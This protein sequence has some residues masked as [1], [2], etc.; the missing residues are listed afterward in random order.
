M[1]V[2]VTSFLDIS[3]FHIFIITAWPHIRYY[4]CWLFLIARSVLTI[5]Y[6]ENNPS[7]P[8]EVPFICCRKLTSRLAFN[9]SDCFP[10]ISYYYRNGL[11]VSS[12]CSQI[13]STHDRPRH[14]LPLPHH[15]HP[16]HHPH[17]PALSICLQPKTK[18]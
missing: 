16:M 15:P 13:D 5:L 7:V 17:P 10:S 11:P 2:E 8:R 12:R 6:F 9:S 4:S 1:D 3:E 14:L 18:G